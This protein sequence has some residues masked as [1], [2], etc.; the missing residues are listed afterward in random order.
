MATPMLY[1][2]RVKGHLA[3]R[4]AEWFPRLTIVNEPNGEATLT[5]AAHD[6]AEL[7]GWLAAV[8]DFGL[9]LISVM[10][11]AA[12]ASPVVNFNIDQEAP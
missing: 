8:R 7:H 12:P 11:V 3:H 2:I 4:G 6:Q 9:P 5:G 10:P 1:Q